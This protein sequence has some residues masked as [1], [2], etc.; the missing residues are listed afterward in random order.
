MRLEFDEEM[1]FSVFVESFASS[2]FF[3]AF[4]YPLKY[5]QAAMTSLSRMAYPSVVMR[6]RRIYDGSGCDEH[7]GGSCGGLRRRCVGRGLRPQVHRFGQGDV[8]VV[9]H[10]VD[11]RSVGVALSQL[12][13]RKQ[14]CVIFPSLYDYSRAF[15]IQKGGILVEKL[16]A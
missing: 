4:S 13:A 2:T 11:V 15:N 1:R 14:S 6:M 12:L 3:F 10:G 5:V 7:H 9:F 16:P 8:R